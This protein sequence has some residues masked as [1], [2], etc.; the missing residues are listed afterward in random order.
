M[1]NAQPILKGSHMNSTSLVALLEKPRVAAALLMA[2]VLVLVTENAGY[3]PLSVPYFQ[4]H[5]GQAYLDMC[6]FCS[7]DAVQARL[8]AFGDRGRLLQALLLGTIDVLIPSLSC[9]AGFAGLA[10]LSRGTRWR[11]LL[12]LPP[13]AMLFDFAE[14]ISIALLVLR[15]PASASGLAAAEGILSGVKFALGGAIVVALL[16]L[17]IT[18]PGRRLKAHG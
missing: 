12:V 13:A 4:H 11:W 9:L 2:L 10:A 14:N 15:W 6:A 1:T 3:F 5:T 16:S 17:V 8:A 18:R 7:S